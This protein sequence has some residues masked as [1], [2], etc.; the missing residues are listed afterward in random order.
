MITTEIPYFLQ[1]KEWYTTP[2]DEGVDLDFFDDGRGYHIKDDAPQEVKD[3]YEEFFAA[4]ENPI[5]QM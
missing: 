3:S 2:E 5:G 1:N 4:I